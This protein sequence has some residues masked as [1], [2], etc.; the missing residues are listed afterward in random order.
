VSGNEENE[1]GLSVVQLSD[2]RQ[3]L[4]F[5]LGAAL[6]ME[7]TIVTVLRELA[8]IANE[9]GLSEQLMRHRDETR[10]QIRN[11]THAFAALGHEPTP[12]PCP[13]IEALRT[14]GELAIQRTTPELQDLVTLA[15]CAEIE[16]HEIAVYE[17]LITLA[18]QLDEADIVALLE[19]NLE[20]EKQAL[21][22]VVTAF[23]QLS[24]ALAERVTA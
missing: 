20:Q 9:D 1:G 23:G 4:V 17:S 24:K 5:K 21:E 19:E 2:P 12:Q 3:F 10:A 15:G 16:H 7:E 22:E 6:T 11:I 8:E 14:E 18:G 13:A